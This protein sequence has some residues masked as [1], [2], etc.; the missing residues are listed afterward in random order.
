MT[1]EADRIKILIVD[2]EKAICDSIRCKIG[3]LRHQ[4]FYDIAVSYSVVD[5]LQLYRQLLPQVVITDLNMPSV[6]GFVF[7][8]ELRKL[9]KECIIFVLSGY[10]DFAYVRKA[11]LS[12]INDYLLKPVSIDELD[13]KLQAYSRKGSHIDVVSAMPQ[14]II[15]KTEEFIRLNLRRNITMKDAAE[16][17]RL[18]YNYFSRVFNECTGSSFPA[19]LLKIRMEYSKKLLADPT[20]R[21]SEIADKIGYDDQNQF[22]RDFKKYIGKSPSQYRNEVIM[23]GVE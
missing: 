20:L 22:S 11:F 9:S 13:E 4:C 1:K 19:Y 3:R 16:N 6:N 21:I 15:A 2:D 17:V 5:A 8:E 12:G 23:N 14:D 18:S 10:N 7:I